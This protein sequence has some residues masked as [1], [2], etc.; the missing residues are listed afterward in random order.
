M[1]DGELF[2]IK[3][4][5]EGTV[6]ADAG[7]EHFITYGIP[8]IAGLFIE[9]LFQN[10]WIARFVCNLGAQRERITQA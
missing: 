9:Q 10:A 4:F 3:Q 1:F 6:S 2:K 5:L 8:L 7:I